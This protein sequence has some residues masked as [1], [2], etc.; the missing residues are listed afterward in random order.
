MIIYQHLL[1]NNAFKRSFLD[2]V[3]LAGLVYDLH[4]TNDFIYDIL[5]K[6]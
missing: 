2:F 6:N 3:G 5:K 1:K 4:L